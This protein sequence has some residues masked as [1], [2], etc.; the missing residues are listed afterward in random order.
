MGVSG[1]VTGYPGPGGGYPV[2]YLRGVVTT[3]DRWPVPGAA[4][5]V[6]S[7]TG[8]QLGRTS[9]DGA[10]GFEVPVATAGVVTIVVAAAGND[11]RAWSA[12]VSP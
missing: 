4:V 5:T 8:Q 12:A 3:A 2:G 11:P 7:A 1:M 9:T 6:L 10:G